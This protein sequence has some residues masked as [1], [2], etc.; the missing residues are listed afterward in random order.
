MTSIAID[1]NEANV[2]Q[3]VG[4]NAYAYEL[5]VAL[6][7]ILRD[8]KDIKVEIL[9]ATPALPD[10]PAEREG[11]S[12]R[13]FGPVPFWTQW[14]L[15]W[16]LFLYRQKYDVFF[17]PGHYAPRLS[18]I[19]YVSSVMDLAYF[20]FHKQFRK[21]D[22]LQLREWTRYSVKHA[23]RIVA[24]SEFTKQD[25]VEKYQ[26][27]ADKV[28]VAYPGLRAEG[29]PVFKEKEKLA[30]LTKWKIHQPYILYVGTLQPRK[31]LEKLIEAFE[32]VVEQAKTERK[33]NRKLRSYLSSDAGK[34]DSLQLVIAGKTGWL[35]DSIMSR[36]E[37]SPLRKRI[38]L[39]GYVTEVEKLILYRESVASVLIG[40]YEGFGIPPLEAM[41]AGTIP[42]VSNTTS[43]PEVVGEAGV[44]VDPEDSASIAAGIKKV[45]F[46]AAKERAALLKKGRQ[47]IKKFHWDESA[48]I[49]LDTLLEVAAEHTK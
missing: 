7:Q 37:T 40:L 47:Q 36:I 5:I 46:Q 28:V 39:T 38:V 10:F 14:A 13:V 15:P 1:G 23:K 19:P 6:E 11:W 48:Q 49:V 41:V 30:T 45:L 27:P 35:A 3:R 34:L 2:A 43:L 31:N 17:T 32:L 29:L 20:D 18:P 22:L 21:K 33:E 25:V 12:Y 8:K 44:Q 9:F 26:I 24:I 4:S 16:Y 42:I